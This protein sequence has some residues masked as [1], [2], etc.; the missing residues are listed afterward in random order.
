MSTIRTLKPPG[1]AVLRLLR[2]GCFTWLES[3]SGLES[4][5]ELGLVSVSALPNSDDSEVEDH[6]DGISGHDEKDTF[7][8]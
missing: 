4:G 6:Q 3:V 5:S 8:I 7:I 1:W 2:L